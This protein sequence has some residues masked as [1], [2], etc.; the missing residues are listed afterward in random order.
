MM[1]EDAS[2][3]TSSLAS[4]YRPKNETAEERRLRKQ[5][6][7]QARRERRVEKKSMQEY[8]KD[9]KKEMDVQRSKI[10]NGKTRTIK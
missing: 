7:K 8:F 6:V 4:T 1:E 10:S 9:T 2:S 5:S 3:I